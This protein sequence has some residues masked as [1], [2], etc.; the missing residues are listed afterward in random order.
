MAFVHV[1]K[2]NMGVGV[3]TSAKVPMAKRTLEVS[4]AFIFP[5]HFEGLQCARQSWA[6]KIQQGTRW[7]FYFRDGRRGDKN[8]QVNT[9]RLF[10][11]A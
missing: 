3:R 8:K 1:C 2:C 4:Q 7:D 6:L 5:I 11:A 10:P 9:G